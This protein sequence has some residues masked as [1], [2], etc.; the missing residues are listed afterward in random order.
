[1]TN[2]Y[3]SIKKTLVRDPWTDFD[4]RDSVFSAFP[5]RPPLN[6]RGLFD[7]DGVLFRATESRFKK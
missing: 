6:G 7:I 5:L 1:M 3:A 4:A 2:K